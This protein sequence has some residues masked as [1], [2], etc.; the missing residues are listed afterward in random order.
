MAENES[1]VVVDHGQSRLSD[2]WTKEDY[3]AIWLGFVI[4][5]AGMWLFLAN[6]SPEFAQKVDKANAVM[7][8][9]AERAPFKTLAYYKAQD[10][11]GKLKAMEIGRAHV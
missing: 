9:E 5:I 3:W 6:P 8:A 10:D 1:N 2:L 4:L 11:K 7:A